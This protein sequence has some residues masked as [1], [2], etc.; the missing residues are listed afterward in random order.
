MDAVTLQII[1]A[2]DAARE[3]V[4]KAEAGTARTRTLKGQLLSADNWHYLLRMR[5]LG[6][7]LNLPA[8][9]RVE[10]FWGFRG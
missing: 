7:S 2:D 9:G 6:E 3:N 10:G 8:T 5:N 4:P 1:Q